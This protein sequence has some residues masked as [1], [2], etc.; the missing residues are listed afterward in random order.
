MLQDDMDSISKAKIP[1]D[2]KQDIYHAVEELVNFS[3]NYHAVHN[4]AGV[5]VFYMA[6]GIMKEAMRRGI[7]SRGSPEGVKEMEKEF[8]EELYKSISDE[9]KLAQMKGE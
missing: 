7:I 9:V 8:I 3:V 4:S 1:L 5:D 6:F 2:I